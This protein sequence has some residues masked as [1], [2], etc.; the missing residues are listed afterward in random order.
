MLQ[1]NKYSEKPILGPQTTKGIIYQQSKQPFLD[2][3]TTTT[4]LTTS[5]NSSSKY[6]N[7]SL[8]QFQTSKQHAT[9]LGPQT[10]KG[11]VGQQSKQPFLDCM[12]TVRPEKIIHDRKPLLTS[13][14]TKIIMTTGYG[15]SRELNNTEL[16]DI[17]SD[18]KASLP[19]YPMKIDGATGVYIDGK[20]IICGGG[21]PV[22]NKCYQL[23]KVGK[24]SI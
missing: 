6:K 16:I 18:C 1:P 3:I 9:I 15:H 10:T 20:I 13:K 2:I 7:P 21:H 24:E 19:D 23:R 12:H 17:N 4:T 14:S 5:S 8:I 22:T 11:K